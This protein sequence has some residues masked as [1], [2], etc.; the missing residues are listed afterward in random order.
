MGL[1]WGNPP[2]SPFFKGGPGQTRLFTDKFLIVSVIFVVSQAGMVRSL[3]HSLRRLISSS[4]K[5]A[6]GLVARI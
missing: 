5:E 3:A 1:H 6:R 4:F 2:K